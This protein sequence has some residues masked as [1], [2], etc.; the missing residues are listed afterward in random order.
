MQGISLMSPDKLQ[1][2]MR[3]LIEN[4]LATCCIWASKFNSSFPEAPVMVGL[5]AIFTIPIAS[6][7]VVAEVALDMRVHDHLEDISDTLAQ[8]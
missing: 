6:S 1:D 8:P 5:S 2:I 4:D 3:F 7:T